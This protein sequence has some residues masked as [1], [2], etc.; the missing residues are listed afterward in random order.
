MAPTPP[1]T[2]TATAVAPEARRARTAVALVFFTNGAILANLIPRY[3]QV[4]EQLGVSDGQLGLAVAAFP[5]GALISGL[6]AGALIRRFRSSRVAMVGTII[7]CV[8]VFLAAL[9][10]TLALFAVGL[11]IAG[12]LDSIVDVSQ[13]SHGL[14]VQRFYGR[15][16]LNAFHAIWS[17]GCVVGGLMGGIAAGLDV[18][19]GLHLA[20]SGAI[21][22]AVS[23]FGYR[24]MLPGP[25]PIEPHDA[26][27][28][29]SVRTSRFTAARVGAIAALV[30]IAAA[31]AIVE[32]SGNSWA[33]IYLSESLGAGATL[34]AFGFVALVGAQ[35]VGRILGDRIVDRFGET[36]VARAGGLLIAVGLGTA[37]AM[38]SIPGTI[39]GFAAA[40]LGCAT[41]VPAAMAAADRLP[42]LAP[43]TGITIVS[44]MMR[45]GFLLAPPVV[46]RIADVTDLR[47]GLVL[48]PLSGVVV[49]LVA[50]VLREN[51]TMEPATS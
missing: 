16:I 28:T 38:P 10:P 35:F 33:A 30:A 24:L 23:I 22:A 47:T 31:G 25:E 32:D 36:A 12:A 5:L 43:G 48:V 17:I 51:R 50:G 44:W 15:S 49:V 26:P 19:L 1:D 11:F 40:G 42:G 18:P 4:K 27:G 41:L 45:F 9:A 39:L 20:V 14:R 46:G 13:N 29:T 37:L 21:F 6:A 3:P 7:M 34:A 8:G 2:P